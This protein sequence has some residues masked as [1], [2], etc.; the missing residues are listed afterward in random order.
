MF[1]IFIYP[2]KQVSTPYIFNGYFEILIEHQVAQLQIVGQFA[3]SEP[4]E[5]QFLRARELE[6]ALRGRINKVLNMHFE[7]SEQ[8]ELRFFQELVFLSWEEIISSFQEL[9]QDFYEDLS[10]VMLLLP[11]EHSSE[12]FAILSSTGVDELWGG[13]S[14][15]QMQER[16]RQEHPFYSLSELKWYPIVREH[17][18][19]SEKG[20]PQEPC[21]SLI[22]R[23]IPDGFVFASNVQ[24]SSKEIQAFF[25]DEIEAKRLM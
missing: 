12:Y 17:P 23:R 2:Q 4:P 16:S 8:H 19:Y 18:F 14:S 22:L 9:E 10:L 1:P 3:A 7:G 24:L 13:L 5:H 15:E 6:A 25:R 21:G 11:V 20:L